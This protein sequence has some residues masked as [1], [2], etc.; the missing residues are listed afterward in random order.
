MRKI[1]FP[2]VF[3]GVFLFLLAGETQAFT[4]K[5]A[6]GSIIPPG[7][8]GDPVPVRVKIGP[9]LSDGK[10]EIGN[11]GQVSCKSDIANWID[12]LY[13]AS[14]ML[15]SPSLEFGRVGI[16]IN[17]VDYDLSSPSLDSIKVLEVTGLKTVS[18][19]VQLYLKI[20]RK[21]P[22]RDIKISKGET[23]AIINFYQKNDQKGCPNCGFYRWSLIAD[24]DAYF[25][26]TTCTINNGKPIDVDFGRIGQ[27]NFTENVSNAVFKKEQSISYH[28]PD[29]NATQDILVRLVSDVSGFSPTAI[30]TSNA[31]VGVVMMYNGNIVKPFETFKSRIQNGMGSD[32]L[33]FVPIKSGVSADKIATGPFSGSATLIFSSP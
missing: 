2:S 11:I 22:S 18:V 13:A 14:V 24:N 25:T 20:N 9:N 1:H 12:Y 23:F 4:C 5:T 31:D 7:G 3:L 17:G 21:G 30:K 33:T 8:S 19:P 16:T 26:T 6:D 10:N 27:D 15:T 32:T 29:S 28:C